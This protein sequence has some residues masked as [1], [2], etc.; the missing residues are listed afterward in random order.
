MAISKTLIDKIKGI[1]IIVGLLT[2]YAIFVVVCF[3]GIFATGK[4]FGVYIAFLVV[5]GGLMIFFTR[6]EFK[7]MIA[8]FKSQAK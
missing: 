4:G 8:Y 2:L 7:K 1:A 3:T 6:E 5:G